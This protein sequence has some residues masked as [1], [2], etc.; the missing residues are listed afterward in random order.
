MSQQRLY[1]DQ[2]HVNVMVRDADSGTRLGHLLDLSLD[3][4]GIAGTG[5]EPE[6]RDYRL[7]FRLPWSIRDRLDLELKAV[8]RWVRHE[9]GA[10][11]Q[12]GF[13]ITSVD[14]EDMALLEHLMTWFSNP[15]R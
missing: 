13:R 15:D 14:N 10:R 12:A 11:W 7:T 1:R 5:A 3:G 2:L 8:C 4:F 9:T 6:K